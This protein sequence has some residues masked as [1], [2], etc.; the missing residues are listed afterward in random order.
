MS[1]LPQLPEH[2]TV[3]VVRCADYHPQSSVD[4]AVRE[5]ARLAAGDDWFDPARGRLVIKP[6]VLAASPPEAAVDA[7]PA[8][9]AGVIRMAQELGATNI[10]V[11]D[12][13]GTGV[14]GATER[15]LEVS[16]IAGAARS[17]SVAVEA[18]ER[19]E[20]VLRANPRG[21]A[22]PSI[23]LA[24]AALEAGTVVSVGKMKTHT[25]TILTGAVKNLYGTVP[26][27]AKRE[28]HQ[29]CPDVASFSA[30]LVD[31]LE[32]IRPQLNIIDAVVAMEGNGPKAGRL[33]RQGLVLAGRDAVAVDAVLAV[34]MGVDP[35][36]VPTT[37]LAAARG[38]GVADLDRIVIKGVPLSEA[39]GRRFRLPT[40]SGLLAR[41]PPGLSRAAVALLATRPAFIPERCTRCG[42]CVR[43]C[44][45]AALTLT[46]D[47]PQL[48][49]APCIACF[50]CHELC[51]IDAIDITYTHPL[52][53]RLVG[54]RRRGG[55]RSGG[56][57]PPPTGR[58]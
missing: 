35:L 13:S 29:R 43:G 58:I 37:R 30:L 17:N 39:R 26:G 10:L 57:Q 50:C 5:A 23:P 49:P 31:I 8:V 40:G 15:A 25:L 16:G 9:V 22:F 11:A 55:R 27:L 14:D 19:G 54:R 45:A 33:R 36:A 46:R 3:A 56:A 4:A 51:P 1:R 20:T 32:L 24:R 44:P 6:N 52:T 34:L 42:A 41:V 47:G 53:A 21:T 18:F 12:S 28:Y 7:H 38:L 2:S 48:D